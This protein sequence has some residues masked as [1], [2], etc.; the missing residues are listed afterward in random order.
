M[1]DLFFVK[2]RLSC[3][4]RQPHASQG[5]IFVAQGRVLDAL[6]FGGIPS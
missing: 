6:K 3:R 5:I 4:A 1:A 2:V